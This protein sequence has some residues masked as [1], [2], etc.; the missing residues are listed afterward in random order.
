[1]K[2]GYFMAWDQYTGKLL[3]KSEVMDYPWD[4]P[5]F[6][7]YAIASAYGLFY[8][9]GYGGIYAFDWDD[10][11]IVWK[12]K[13][14]A[15]PYE[16][17]Y[18]DE[19]GATVYSWN[20]GGIIADG[21]LYIYNTE[22]TPTPPITRGWGLHCINATTGEGI[23]NIT[24]P[25]PAV[26]ADGYLSVGCSDGYQYVF[27][28]GQTAT[29]VTAPDVEV[30][31][32]TSVMIRGTVLDMSPAQ[33]DT[34][35]VSKESM[36]TWMEYLHKQQPIDGMWHN[37]TITG[38]PVTLTAI[39]SDGNYIDLGT[40]T[41]SGYYGTFGLAWTPT[42]EGTYEIIAS[43]ESDDSYGSSGASTYVTVGP[44]PSAAI[45]PEAEA[46]PTVLITTEVAIIAA[47]AVAAVIGI[48]A[49]WALRKRK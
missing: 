30:P 11:S 43:F 40:V 47:V 9:F 32:G 22:H 33:P 45:E 34:P 19:N 15:N 39:D 35:C 13:A 6:G 36:T 18:V 46:E 42:E 27:G 17:P 5:G 26:V 12:Y 49:Y 10:G 44:A 4:E 24:T 7:A 23:L 31:K 3:W 14:P 41:T 38:V 25:G 28:K 2:E 29:T 48:V 16:T 20:S 8:R 1:M 21:K 37:E